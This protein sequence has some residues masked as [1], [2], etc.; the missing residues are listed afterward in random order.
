MRTK[1]MS[2]KQKLMRNEK[3]L[4]KHV[5]KAGQDP[6]AHPHHSGVVLGKGVEVIS[7]LCFNA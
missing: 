3:M 5:Y 1:L 2:K 6:L 4:T 7:A